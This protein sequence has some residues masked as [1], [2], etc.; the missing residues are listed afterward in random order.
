[1]SSRLPQPKQYIESPRSSRKSARDGLVLLWLVLAMF[2][3]RLPEASGYEQPI[4]AGCESRAAASQP[5]PTSC[6]CDLEGAPAPEHC[7][8]K[9]DAENTEVAS[10]NGESTGCGCSLAPIDRPLR[11]PADLARLDSLSAGRSLE[12]LDELQR[13]SADT[14]A[15][16]AASAASPHSLDGAP[17]PGG[18]DRAR[19]LSAPGSLAR[20]R[21]LQGGAARF[22]A[23]LSSLLI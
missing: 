4:G 9:S 17:P 22:L 13:V 3:V 1:M 8:M 19:P 23:E 7:P 5:A 10:T 15:V 2:G 14:P 12:T 18:A 16:G 20:V 21:W 6:C 11:L